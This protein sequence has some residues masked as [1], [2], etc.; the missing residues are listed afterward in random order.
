MVPPSSS[1]GVSQVRISV[2]NGLNSATAATQFTYNSTTLPTIQSISPTYVSVRGGIVHINGS[3]FGNQGVS[4]LVGTKSVLVLTASNNFIAIQLNA[5]APGLYPVQVET[6]AG[7]ARPLV[8]IEYR[9]YIQQVTPQVGS[10]YGG[11]DLLVHGIGF[12]TGTRIQLRDR[13]NEISSC[14]TISLQSNLI[15][16]RTKISAPQVTIT[17]YGT[18]PTLGFGY[19]WFPIRE[20]VQQGAN[21]TWYWDASQLN[22]PVPY[23]IQQVANAYS[24]VPVTN[25][26]DSGSPSSIGNDNHIFLENVHLICS[27][28]ILLGS[29]SHT[30]DKI[31]TY[32][33][34]APNVHP[35]T[36]YAMRGVIEVVA[37]ESKTLTVE[38]VWNDFPG[39]L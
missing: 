38:A 37:V 33:Y 26:F 14:D 10:A 24:T 39:T 5:R 8:Y 3:G 13:N 23:K 30:F 27:Y 11:T 25:G 17:S 31:D 15:H 1:G 28:F 22:T 29:F 21:V 35:A 34:W 20:T 32:Y 7:F 19:S 9:F 4:V 16:C 2:S 36:G 12:E 6:S 18:H